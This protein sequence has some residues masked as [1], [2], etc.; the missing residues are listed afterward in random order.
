MAVKN[1][2]SANHTIT[3]SWD[4][5]LHSAYPAGDYPAGEA[6]ILYTDIVAGPTSGGETDLGCYIRVTGVNF[7]AF[8]DWGVISHLYIGGVEVANYRYLQ[9]ARG[10]QDGRVELCAQV[11][12]LGGVTPGVALNITMSVRGSALY[13]PT[14][15]LALADLDGIALTFTPQPGPIVFVALTGSDSAAGTIDAPLQHLQTYDGSSLYGGAVY[16]PLSG[17][18]VDNQIVPGT[19]IVLRG[20][21]YGAHMGGD[22]RWCHF[23]RRTGTAP[24]GAA[25]SGPICIYPYPGPAGA[26]TPETVSWTGVSGSNGGFQFSDTTRS[27]ETTPWGTVGY[28]KYIHVSNLIIDAHPSPSLPL[29]DKAPIEHQTAADYCRVINCELSWRVTTGTPRSGG[30]GGEGTYRELFGNYIHDIYG[31]TDLGADGAFENHGIYTGN[32]TSAAG[33]AQ[34]DYHTRICYNRIEDVN[35]SGMNIRGAPVYAGAPED[36]APYMSIHH[37]RIVRAGKHGITLFDGRARANIHHNLTVDVAQSP[38][39]VNVDNVTVAGGIYY[40]HN[41]NVGWGTFATASYPA[42]FADGGSNTGSVRIENN[43]FYCRAGTQAPSFDRFFVSRNGLAFTFGGNCWYDASGY[44]TKPTGDTTGIQTD[45][46]LT[47]LTTD[48]TPQAASP[49]IDAAAANTSVS[50]TLYAFDLDYIARPQGEATLWA[51]GAMERPA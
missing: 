6:L 1:A 2:I 21:E 32:N 4:G 35:G 24:S 15:G 50:G 28:T 19:H 25:K 29:N 33:A 22:N 36:S 51:I 49:L 39:F 10:A 5:F 12:A 48:F 27:A 45:P 44:G 23:F 26:N 20:G 8:A 42:V 46:L 34:A 31:I 30:I 18:T 7:G 41:T 11:G 16:G 13:N 40:G 9:T 17:G 47:N 14:V 3:E 43:V 38:L 37:N